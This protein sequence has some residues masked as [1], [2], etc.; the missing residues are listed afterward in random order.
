MIPGNQ[1]EGNPGI[2]EPLCLLS[3]KQAGIIIPP[4]PVIEI[5]RN[6]YE[7]DAFINGQIHKIDQC[8]ARGGADDLDRSSLVLLQSFEWT[9]EVDVGGMDKSK[10]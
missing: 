8:G 5:P 9:V 10:H 3:E 2:V 1:V 7:G 6:Q 4:V